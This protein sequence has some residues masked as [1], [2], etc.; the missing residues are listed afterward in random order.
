MFIRIS[1]AP[2]IQYD[3]RIFPA[4]EGVKY[5]HPPYQTIIEISN[6]STNDEAPERHHIS[7]IKTI[8]LVI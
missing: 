3:S 5:K 4:K 1:F 2:L 8:L 6:S 7:T